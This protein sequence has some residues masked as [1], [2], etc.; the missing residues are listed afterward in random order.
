MNCTEDDLARRPASDSVRHVIAF[1][2]ARA[3]H[4]LNEGAPLART[5]PWRA[6]LAVTGFVAGGLAALGAIERARYDVL[7]APP[8]ASKGYRAGAFLSIAIRVARG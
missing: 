7:G 1:E 6:A 2:A 3:R 4:L 5:L 8:R